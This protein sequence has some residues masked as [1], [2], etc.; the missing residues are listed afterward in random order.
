MGIQDQEES[1]WLSGPNAAYIESFYESWLKDPA[2]VPEEWRDYFSQMVMSDAGEASREVLHSEIVTSLANQRH[3]GVVCAVT[4][5]PSFT[6]P[7][8]TSA[9]ARCRSGRF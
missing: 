3:N 2:S 7:T 9:R 5:T 8:P 6:S 4:L 1:D